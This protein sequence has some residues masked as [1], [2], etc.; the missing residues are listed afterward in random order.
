M[1]ALHVP[2]V[3]GRKRDGEELRPDELDAVLEGYLAGEVPEYQMSALLMAIVFRGMTDAELDRWTRRLVDSG[4][5]WDWSPVEGAKVDKHSTGGVGDKVSLVLAPLAAA[6]GLKVPMVSGRGLGHTGG[7]LDK[8]EVIPGLRTDLDRSDVARLLDEAGFAMGGQTA[9]FAPLDRELY[10]LRDVTAT[11]ESVPL[12]AASIISKK[13]AEGLDALVLDV[14]TGSGAFLRERARAEELARRMIGLARRMGLR[15]EAL[16]TAMDQP[17]GRAVGHALEVREA[18]EAL[19]GEGPEDLREVT[20][21]LTSRL[22]AMTARPA[23]KATDGGAT[24]ER[25]AGG[26]GGSA[27][28]HRAL[29]DGSAL[30]R[31]RRMVEGQGGDPRVVDD[32]GRLP[33]A[34]AVVEA[35]APAAGWVQR[36]DAREVGMLVLE[37]GGGRRRKGDEIDLAVGV[38]LDRKVGDEVRPGERLARVHAASEAAAQRGARRLAEIYVVGE[39]RPAPASVIQGVVT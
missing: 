17:L 22:L 30:E 13:V 39:E 8:L 33:A 35:R 7:T 34:P 5:R 38:V 6:L 31:F 2:S 18:L 10:A 20:V 23:A 21:A 29:E 15:A 12:I 25:R 19:R 16:L 32:P 1:N 11:V 37:L 28:I 14:K 4:E 9:A 27:A 36:L 24:S 3:I 26:P